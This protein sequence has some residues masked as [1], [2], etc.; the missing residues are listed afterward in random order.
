MNAANT[1]SQYWLVGAYNSSFGT[2]NGLT[3][4]DDYFKLKSITFEA[5]EVAESGSLILLLFG[6]AGLCFARR[7][8]A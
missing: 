3:K 2:G 5:V 7:R 1:H 8:A 6:L 4:K